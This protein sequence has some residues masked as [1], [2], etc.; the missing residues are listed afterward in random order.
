[1]KQE[2]NSVCK[3]MLFPFEIGC[4]AGEERTKKLGFLS[5]LI[6]HILA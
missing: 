1:V 2:S 5:S 6:A 3:K 4:G